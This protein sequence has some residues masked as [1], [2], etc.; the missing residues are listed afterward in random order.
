MLYI[1]VVKVSYSKIVN[2]T[3]NH[4]IL[5]LL[6]NYAKANKGSWLFTAL[7][8][9][10]IAQNF[11]HISGNITILLTCH[12]PTYANDGKCV[13]RRSQTKSTT[14]LVLISQ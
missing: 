6:Q 2:S 13:E 3:P 9:R 10:F 14:S 8:C 1:A 7:L 4:F 12:F 11:I 5:K